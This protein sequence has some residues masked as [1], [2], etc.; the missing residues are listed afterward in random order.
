MNVM[1]RLLRL[2]NAVGTEGY[3]EARYA[4]KFCVTLGKNATQ[5]Y[6]LLQTAYGLT[7]MSRASEFRWHKMFKES[8][9]DDER[10]GKGTEVR[11]PELLGKIRTVMDEDR[12]VTME[13]ISEQFEVNVETTH[14]IIHDE[15]N[16]R[17]ISAKFVPRVLSGRKDVLA[18]A[19]R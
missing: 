8:V 6:E 17:K 4:I 13:T 11:T 16:M 15:L 5:T 14:K 10:C 18:T 12:R 3:L 19:G 9:R 1:L 2:Q 7:C